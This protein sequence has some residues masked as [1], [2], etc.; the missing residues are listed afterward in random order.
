MG[1]KTGRNKT[2]GRTKGTLNK[3][4]ERIRDVLK[5]LIDEQQIVQDL[6]ELEPKER[7]NIIVKFLPYI[8]PKE[9]PETE[10]KTLYDSDYFSKLPLDTQIGFLETL[11]SA[12]DCDL[13]SDEI[14]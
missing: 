9:Q 7:L 13:T 14:V 12:R 2:G 8:L 6:S 1:F 3:T 4:T 10:N 11:R 5:G